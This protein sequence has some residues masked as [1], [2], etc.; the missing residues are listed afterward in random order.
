MPPRLIRAGLALLALSA[1]FLPAGRP[2]AAAE[3]EAPALI[4]AAIRA[5]LQERL[6]ALPGAT[7]ETGMIDPR[8]RLPACPALDVGLPGTGA[9]AMT[10]KVTCPAP[11]WTIYV[12]VRLHAWTRAVVAA[13]NLAPNTALTA[14]DLARGRVDRFASP[15]GLVS[16]PAR[17][18]GRILRVGLMA[19][20]PILQSF[21]DRPVLVHRGEKVLMS[22]TGGRMV[23][24]DMAV[25]L[26]DGRAGQTITVRNPESGK[27]VE[28]TVARDGTVAVRF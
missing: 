21:L 12:P 18:R 20:A 8:L 10:A 1:A 17:A 13:T 2:A 6:A 4:R 9:P 23:V 19:G 22:V 15:G 26:E 27:I 24:R 14:A 3:T 11:S 28:A 5:A 7:A 16:D 25:A